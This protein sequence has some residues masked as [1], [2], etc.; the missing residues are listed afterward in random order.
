MNEN[1][2]RLQ[3]LVNETT[4]LIHNLEKE[5][6]NLGKEYNKS[7][8]VKLDE[9]RLFLKS[10]V[11]IAIQ[12]K[13]TIKV[14]IKVKSRYGDVYVIGIRAGY[15][16]LVYSGM[17]CCLDD[18]DWAAKY[19][20]IK[21]RN[22]YCNTL[23]YDIDAIIDGFDQNDFEIA[24]SKAVQEVLVRR[25]EVANQNYNYIKDKLEAERK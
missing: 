9:I 19:D 21:N 3:Q 8:Q 14:P 13:T 4:D 15:S 18:I 24:F 17:D 25:A 20:D 16:P 11:P 1:I 2:M 10:L 6:D 23:T 12:L 22:R 7:R 5:T